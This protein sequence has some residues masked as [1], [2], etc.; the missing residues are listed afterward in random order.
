MSHV[1]GVIGISSPETARHALFYSSLTTVTRPPNVGLVHAISAVIAQNRN[2]IAD[3][4]LAEG[5][6]WVWYVDDDQYFQPD[7]LQRLL[8]HDVDIV[9]GLYLQRSSPFRPHVYHKETSTGSVSTR[10]LS[11]GD[12]GVVSV[13]AVGA[14]CL[15]V[16][17][18]V[19]KALE[20]PY[21]RLGQIHPAEW[22]DD[23]DFCRRVRAKGFQIWC[24]LDLPVG[25]FMTGIVHPAKTPEGEWVTALVQSNNPI[26][27]IAIWNA[28]FVEKPV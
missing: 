19:F 15:L 27:P 17:T 23:I 16:K 12:A 11:K 5:A 26:E 2:H 7:T 10:Y 4:A 28:A 24:D 1:T 20:P 22:G 21:W 13:D 14:G 9:S 8:A 6:E 25:H 3:R 18:T